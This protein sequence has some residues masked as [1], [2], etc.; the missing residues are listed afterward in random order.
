MPVAAS[1]I[2]HGKVFMSRIPQIIHSRCST[3]YLV[4]AKYM[5]AF[6]P[7]VECVGLRMLLH[8]DLEA[9]NVE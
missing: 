8:V 5:R 9:L 1:R 4:Q 7:P 3:G 2:A 6:V